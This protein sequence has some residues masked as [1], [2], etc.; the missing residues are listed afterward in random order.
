M[1]PPIDLERLAEFSDGTDEGLRTLVRIFLEDVAE[2]LKELRGAVTRGDCPEIRVLA[3]RSAG[4]CGACGAGRLAEL[5]SGLEEI[6]RSGSS[7]GSTES[8]TAIDAEL[9]RVT[10]FVKAHLASLG[11]TE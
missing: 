6:G 5:L 11:E 4:S 10:L 9:E 3:H 8:M 7:E 1:R 2:A